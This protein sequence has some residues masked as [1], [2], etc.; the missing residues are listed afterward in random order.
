[1]AYAARVQLVRQQIPHASR[2][3]HRFIPTKLQADRTENVY[4]RLPLLS[5]VIR[6][7]QPADAF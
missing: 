7:F 2:V 4:E 3:R 6:C 1:M 5:H